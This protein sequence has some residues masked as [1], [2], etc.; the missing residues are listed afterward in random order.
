MTN[1]NYD[2]AIIGGGISGTLILVRMLDQLLAADHPASLKK[3]IVFDKRGEF[4]CGM[5]YGKT[6]AEPGFLLIET[7]ALSTPPEFQQWL[8]EH[9]LTFL[10]EFKQSP[11][12]ALQAW[13][14]RN[15]EDF[16]LGNFA[17]MY[18]P[19]QIF[20]RYVVQLLQTKVAA[21]TKSK[22]AEVTFVHD[23]VVDLQ[24]FNA[25]F[26]IIANNNQI[27]ARITVMAVGLCPRPLV[28]DLGIEDGYLH[29][30]W[31]SGYRAVEQLINLRYSNMQR[32][33]SMI[34]MG[35][36]ATAGDLIYFLKHRTDLLS[37]IKSILSISRKGYFAGVAPGSV[38]A[39][40][41]DRPAAKEYRIA[42]HQMVE[43]GIL[44]VISAITQTSPV[45]TSTDRLALTTVEGD[46]QFEADLIINCN[47]MGL[48]NTTGA[49]LIKNITQADRLF[50]R[51]VFCTGF[52]LA[53]GTTEV[54][55][56]KNCFIIGPM[57]NRVE[58]ETHVESI[59]GVYRAVGELAPILWDRLMAEQS[60]RVNKHCLENT[61]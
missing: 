20:G 59:H 36:A 22:L 38:E 17:Q 11:D 53:E 54:E 50:K 14:E 13:V 39:P 61:L 10:E 9:R 16:E 24:P 47:G 28:T 27:S 43:M 41:P 12:P 21:A 6:T 1:H 4:G 34:V 57:L 35:S 19:R 25:G 33:L 42:A 5:P 44:T 23:E 56:V 48:I 60:I 7:V 55:A 31:T 52:E 37:K 58:I 15:G 3:F 29:D 30:I 18:I 49:P 2:V 26:R 8:H 46:Q 51:N 32:P 45:K 40:R